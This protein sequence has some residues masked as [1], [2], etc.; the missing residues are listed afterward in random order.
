[1]QIQFSKTISNDR[2]LCVGS[3]T[4]QEAEGAG[5]LSRGGG[6]GYFLYERDVDDDEEVTV[7]ARF[8]SDEAALQIAE[9]ID[10]MRV[11]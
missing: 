10:R 6:I 11:S 4:R 3:L 5:I 7:L 2:R 1:M 8:Y 9:L